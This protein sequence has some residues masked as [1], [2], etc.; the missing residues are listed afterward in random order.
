MVDS[1]ATRCLAR[2]LGAFID[3]KYRA[4]RT[5]AIRKT[6]V[7]TAIRYRAE[8]TAQQVTKLESVIQ[9]IKG[10]GRKQSFKLFKKQKSDKY[11]KRPRKNAHSLKE[12][13]I[14]CGSNSESFV[15]DNLSEMCRAL[16]I[17]SGPLSASDNLRSSLKRNP[18]SD[19]DDQ[20]SF[21]KDR[22]D[23]DVP[24]MQ[25]YEEVEQEMFSPQA[26]EMRMEDI[27]S[28]GPKRAADRSSRPM[29]NMR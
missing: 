25:Y 29:P 21:N 22:N 26:S 5:K 4:K 17:A 23:D 15:E 2:A 28:G 24:E 20:F 8:L 27:K 1:F 10:E 7:T 18:F 13:M 19:A 12:S 3:P 16:L 11:L 6:R 9:T 14:E